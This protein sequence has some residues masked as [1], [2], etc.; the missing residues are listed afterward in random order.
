M[1][2]GIVSFAKNYLA[3]YFKLDYINARGDISNDYPDFFVKLN[4]GRIVV[5]ETKGQEDLD[6][7][8]KIQRLRQGSARTSMRCNRI[9]VTPS[10]MSMKKASRST[11]RSPFRICWPAFVSIRIDPAGPHA[12]CVATAATNALS[13]I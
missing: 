13:T 2:R 8:L 1:Q 11:R 5:V 7:P 4:D 3:V 12:A 10:Y 9:C 6:A